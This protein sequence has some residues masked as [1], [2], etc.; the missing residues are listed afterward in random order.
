MSSLKNQ[1]DTLE[2]DMA[3]A[4]SN[5]TASAELRQAIANTTVQ[6]RVLILTFVA[7]AIALVSLFVAIHANNVTTG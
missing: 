2:R 7:I 4:T 1:A 6:R 5:I 3:A